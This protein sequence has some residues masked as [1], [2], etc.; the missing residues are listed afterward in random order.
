M[1]LRPANYCTH[2]ITCLF[3]Q[4]KNLADAGILTET[5]AQNY[6]ALVYSLFN[7][8]KF[9]LPEH[10]RMYEFSMSGRETLD[11]PEGQEIYFNRPENCMSFTPY[12]V[13]SWATPFPITAFEY[14]H[15]ERNGGRHTFGEL[16]T[17]RIVLC[18]DAGEHTAITGVWWFDHMQ[19]WLPA[20]VSILVKKVTEGL[21]ISV[22]PQFEELYG[23][24]DIDEGLYNDMYDEITV[25][26]NVFTF[27]RC[28]NVGIESISAPKSLNKKRAKKK[29]VP[30]FEYRVL[31]LKQDST[32]KYE[33]ATNGR[34]RKSP[35][36]HLR[37][38]HIRTYASGESTFVTACMVGKDGDGFLHKDYRVQRKSPERENGAFPI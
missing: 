23:Q 4:R 34:K 13:D 21:K 8:I 22:A 9:V 24:C 37:R 26:V 35:R 30:L 19:T 18:M 12:E 6:S 2:A 31:E 32:I 11:P 15:P 28:N 29:K 14:S 16:S 7:A 1:R 5:G 36:M 3:E 10:G 17:R 38:G 25:L 27:L 33:P 20:K